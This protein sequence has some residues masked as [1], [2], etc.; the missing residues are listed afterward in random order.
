VKA[1]TNA[2]QRYG[3][4]LLHTAPA[5]EHWVRSGSP[6]VLHDLLE[7]SQGRCPEF[8]RCAETLKKRGDLTCKDSLL[9]AWQI[10]PLPTLIHLN[11]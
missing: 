4:L 8:S 11:G 6:I 5:S 7:W 3:T 9:K 1:S 2:N 10:K